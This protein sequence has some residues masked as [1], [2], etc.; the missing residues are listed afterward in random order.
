MEE[1]ERL[2]AD[3]IQ[4]QE[5]KDTANAFDNFTLGDDFDED[6]AANFNL[7]EEG[8]IEEL[9]F[10]QIMGV[11]AFQRAQQKEKE[12]EI[13]AD[14]AEYSL[15]EGPAA[16]IVADAIEEESDDMEEFADLLDW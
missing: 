11:I 14:I 1:A 4:A 16:A 8:A 6:A 15:D 9:D 2:R 10:N 3:A 5:A 12:S 7:E 13:A